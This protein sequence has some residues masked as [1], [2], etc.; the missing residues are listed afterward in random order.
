MARVGGRIWTRG[1]RTGWIGAP[2]DAADDAL[3]DV[4]VLLTA[5]DDG[6]RT[7]AE[8][9]GV[10]FV[11]GAR[12]RHCRVAV[13][14]PTFV[15]AFPQARWLVGDDTLRRWRGQLDYWVF[16]DG[17]L[18]RVTGSVNGP[19]DSFSGRRD[20][21]HDP[22]RAR[23]DRPRRGPVD[24]RAARLTR[25]RAPVDPRRAAMIDDERDRL[26]AKRD[27]TARFYRVVTFLEGRGER[28]ATPAEIAQAVGMSKRT[29]YRDLVAIQDELLIP[30]WEDGGRYGLDEK[31]LLPALRLTQA[32]AMAVF[33]SARLMARY[34][35]AYDPDLAAA[36]QKLASGLPEVL[37]AHVLRTFDLLSQRAP[38]DASERTINQ[39]LTR[40]WAER[41]VVEI[42]YR[43]GTY[44]PTKG[45]RTTRVRPY[46]IEPSIATRA[47]Y[48]IGWD[49]TRGAIRTFKLE[50]IEDVVLTAETFEAPPEGTIEETFAAAWDIIA[51]QPVVEVVLRFSPAVA[52]RVHE[53]R[54]HPSER[55]EPADD[56]SLTWRARVSGTLEIRSWILGWGADVEVLEPPELREE[57]AG[58]LRAAAGRTIAADG[59]APVG[60]STYPMQ[61]AP[62]RGRRG[63]AVVAAVLALTAIAV[64]LPAPAQ[65]STETSMEARCSRGSTTTGRCAACARCAPTRASRT[66]PGSARPGWPRRAS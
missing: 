59:M 61:S 5:L 23:R 12:G 3:V 47:L 16:T 44:D 4:Q 27:R 50:R 26:S 2:G 17:E 30:I 42:S 56:G 18:G 10:E 15:A 21:G 13:D 57:I 7:T 66:C 43:G 1:P 60:Y 64:T 32:E 55:L 37:A 14:G 62:A 33:L 19:A 48:L 25:D 20:P 11:E 35:D 38:D 41:R 65:A 36:F 34:A 51:D 8:N 22:G 52:G 58:I 6:I 54:W 49:E 31:G 53:T 39:R 46:L 24:R 9:H 28:G 40:A 63:L 45:T 29:A